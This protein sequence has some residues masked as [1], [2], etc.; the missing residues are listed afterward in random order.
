MKSVLLVCG[1]V[2]CLFIGACGDCNPTAPSRV[3]VQPVPEV[4]R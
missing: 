4:R 1:L 3:K 2:V